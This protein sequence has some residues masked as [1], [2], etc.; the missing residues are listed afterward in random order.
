MRKELPIQ[1]SP[2]LAAKCDDINQERH[3][4]D[5][6]KAVVRKSPED[7]QSIIKASKRKQASKKS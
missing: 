6:I 7:A 2:E 3:F 1:I 4:D 5:A